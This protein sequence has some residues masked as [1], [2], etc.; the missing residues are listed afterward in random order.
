[1][2]CEWMGLALL[3]QLLVPGALAGMPAHYQDVLVDPDVKVSVNF[4]N[5]DAADAGALP[6]SILRQA[7]MIP[8]GRRSIGKALYKVNWQLDLNQQP[9]YCHL[10]GVRVRTAVEVQMPNWLQL[11]RLPAEAQGSW[12]R[13]LGA[14]LEYESRH[15]EIVVQASRVIGEGI[16]R[17]PVNPSCLALRQAADALGQ[18]QL[19]ATRQQVRR[20]Q[21]ETAGGQHLGMTLPVSP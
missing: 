4:Y 13:F 7:P 3:S 17:L 2:R 10:F 18:R 15:K 12:N 11:S 16:A 6:A 8:N 14:M 20:Y 1:M 5:L 19:E 9:D 21:T